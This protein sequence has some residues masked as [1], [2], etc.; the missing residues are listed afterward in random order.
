MGRL[1]GKLRLKVAERTDKRVRI[2]SEIVNA[3]R[4]IKMYAWEMPFAKLIGDARE[5]VTNLHLIQLFYYNSP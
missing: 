4:I 3:V 1:F 2:M 5:Y